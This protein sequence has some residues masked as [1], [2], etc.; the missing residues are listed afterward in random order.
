MKGSQGQFSGVIG[1]TVRLYRVNMAP[2]VLAVSI[3]A[4]VTLLATLALAALRP[5][6]AVTG[7]SLGIVVTSGSGG[8]HVSVW[9]AALAA[10]LVGIAASAW[11]T[12]T[13]LACL[14]AHLRSGRRA[15]LDALR[16]GFVFWAQVALAALLMDL[17]K[18]AVS[19]LLPLAV[20]QLAFLASLVTLVLGLLFLFY[21]QEVVVAGRNGLAALLESSR[22]VL[23]VGFWRVLGTYLLGVLC[24][25]PFLAVVGVLAVATHLGLRAGWPLALAVFVITLVLGPWFAAFT[26]V[27]YC[28]AIGERGSLTAVVP[29]PGQVGASR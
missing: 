25:A 5:H 23:R 6:E 16:G 7:S 14:F 27:M 29:A 8:T 4:T 11:S 26:T 24:V 1:Y 12:A 9:F 21:A 13:M 19:L 22:L 15:R 18:K 20:F 2:L 10:G 3:G 28:L 17:L